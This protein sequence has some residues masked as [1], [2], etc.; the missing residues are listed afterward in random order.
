MFGLAAVHG[1]FSLVQFH[2]LGVLDPF[3]SVL[4][5]DGSFTRLETLPFQVFGLLALGVLFMM[6]A[7]SHDFWLNNL[8]AP[9]WKAL[10]LMVYVA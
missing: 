1:L 9:V 2:A 6:A 10:H 4:V 3:V 5:S 7:T 8:S